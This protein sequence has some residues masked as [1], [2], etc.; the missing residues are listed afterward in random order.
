MFVAGVLIMAAS[1]PGKVWAARLDA[2]WRGFNDGLNRSSS[3][4]RLLFGECSLNFFSRQDKGDEH[5][6]AASAGFIRRR[7]GWQTGQAIA[8]VDLLFD[9][10]EQVLILRHGQCGG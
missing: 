10:E 3:E 7:S 5:G 9:C 8:A 2:M 1:A 4:A 6:L